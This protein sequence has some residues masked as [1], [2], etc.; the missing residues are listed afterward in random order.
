VACRTAGAVGAR[1]V[2][3]LA[4][5]LRP[6]GRPA[7]G[8]DRLAELRAA[9]AGGAAVLALSGERDPFG[10]PGRKDA[11]RVVVVSGEAHALRGHHAVITGAVARWLPKV[12]AT[13]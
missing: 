5:P 13:A 11:D 12:L 9:R 10:I 7:A 3:A 2:I 8:Q 1:A 4:F 6:P